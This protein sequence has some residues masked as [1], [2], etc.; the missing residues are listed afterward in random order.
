MKERKILQDALNWI[1]GPFRPRPPIADW[2]D[3]LLTQQERQSLDGKSDEIKRTIER[4]RT[5]IAMIARD[6]RRD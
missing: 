2:S 3:D 4:L 5:E 6:H 1:R